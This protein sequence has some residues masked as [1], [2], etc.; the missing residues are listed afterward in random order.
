MVFEIGDV[1]KEAGDR[2]EIDL[3]GMPEDAQYPLNCQFHGPVRLKGI[4]ANMGDGIELKGTVEACLDVLC[5]R[6]LREMTFPVLAEVEAIFQKE[7][8]EDSYLYEGDELRLD[9]MILDAI[10]FELPAQYL[11]KEDCKGLCPKCGADLN[12]TTCG[13]KAEEGVRENPFEKLKGLF[14]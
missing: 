7:E 6:C 8:S 3:S 13:C 2:A 9:K 14:D 11:C 4:C 5:S 10:S 12:T 1:L